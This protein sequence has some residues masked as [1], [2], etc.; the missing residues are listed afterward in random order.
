MLS[1][2]NKRILLFD[3]LKSVSSLFM[4]IYHS[5][6]YQQYNTYYYKKRN[7]KCRYFVNCCYVALTRTCSPLFMM[8]TGCLLLSPKRLNDKPSVHRK[9][10][11]KR[12]I[13]YLFWVFPY[14]FD[15][16]KG[17]DYENNRN[18]S[19]K[20][21]I[22]RIVDTQSMFWYTKALLVIHLITPAVQTS[23]RKINRKEAEVLLIIFFFFFYVVNDVRLFCK[24][25]IL[26]SNFGSIFFFFVLGSYLFQSAEY[27]SNP[28]SHNVS[29]WIRGDALFPLL[30]KIDLTKKKERNILIIITF[31]A[32]LYGGFLDY[33]Y[34][35]NK[36]YRGLDFIEL[37][38]PYSVFLSSLIFL[39]FFSCFR[40]WNPRKNYEIHLSKFFYSSGSCS[41]GIFMINEL[42]IYRI[43]FK[44]VFPLL[45]LDWYAMN[46]FYFGPLMGLLS[47]LF[48]WRLSVYI[49][50]MPILK[51]MIY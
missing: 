41:M 32:I 47:F 22:F 19:F 9:Y 5:S 49:K 18:E 40:K 11:F 51:N 34:Q 23:L 20:R 26:V 21:I 3:A 17:Y 28:S 31:I 43:M 24:K 4:T 35:W 12:L 7:L 36:I 1:N 50:K 37:N 6:L 48:C 16:F 45:H 33:F 46:T 10:Y 13:E 42:F 2:N 44:R 38:N 29:G 30:N 15:E 27:S 8:V 14:Y 25:R 39:L